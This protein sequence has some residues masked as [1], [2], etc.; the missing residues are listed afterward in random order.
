MLD[1][2]HLGRLGLRLVA[3]RGREGPY[4]HAAAER[5]EFD[6]DLF[7][8]GC[9]EETLFAENRHVAPFWT[10]RTLPLTVI[11]WLG[12]GRT[13]KPPPRG[14]SRRFL[15]GPPGKPGGT[16]VGELRREL[17]G[18]PDLPRERRI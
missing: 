7:E 4:A 17:R 9:F 12:M 1:R 5:R 2:D 3:V 13:A 6:L 18:V 10:A 11:W 14:E 16:G 15:H 8:I